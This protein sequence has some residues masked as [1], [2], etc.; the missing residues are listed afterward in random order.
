MPRAATVGGTEAWD[1]EFEHAMQCL[2]D[3]AFLLTRVLDEYGTEHG[4]VDRKVVDVPTQ[5]FGLACVTFY[6]SREIS[7]CTA[8]VEV[9]SRLK[10]K[11]TELSDA[12][13]L[14]IGKLENSNI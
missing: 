7:L 5:G 4:G 8:H 11:R 13:V 6:A 10:F 3:F 2:G 14:C 9:M 12:N 1:G